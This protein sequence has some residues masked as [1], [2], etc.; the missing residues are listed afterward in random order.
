MADNNSVL[1]VSIVTPDGKVYEREDAR[2]VI[3]R[4]KSGQLGIMPNHVPVIA[5]LE[6][7]EV[8]VKSGSDVD[9]IA[10]NGGFVEFSNNNLTVIADSAEKQGDIDVDRAAA[11]RDRAQKA[12]EIARQKHDNQEI[13]RNQVALRRAINRIHVAKH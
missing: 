5:S 2:L 13:L 9:E 8:K 6:V 12:L 10:V 11:A 3:V 1:T 4:T 7:D